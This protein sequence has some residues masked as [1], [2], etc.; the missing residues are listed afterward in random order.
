[1]SGADQAEAKVAIVAAM[2]AQYPRDAAV[3]Y[4]ATD[5]FGAVYAACDKGGVVMIAGTGSNCTLIN[6]DESI[7]R[8]GGWGHM[9]GDEGSGESGRFEAWRSTALLFPHSLRHLTHGH[10]VR[11]RCG[12][13][14]T[15]R[16]FLHPKVDESIS[17]LPSLSRRRTTTAT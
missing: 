6:P 15:L 2:R 8:C 12:G 9:M 4:L 13:Q 14:G 5:T 10:Q 11:F 17:S 1:M 3:H 16:A 7:V